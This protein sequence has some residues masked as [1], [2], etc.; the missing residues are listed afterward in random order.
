MNGASPNQGKAQV[1]H[2][3]SWWQLCSSEFDLREANVVCRQLG[4]VRAQALQFAVYIQDRVQWMHVTCTGSEFSLSLCLSWDT[5]CN[6]SQD[7][8][9]VCSSECI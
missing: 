2:N 4:Y 1:F 8:T 7:M 9:I 5:L 3:G 6:S